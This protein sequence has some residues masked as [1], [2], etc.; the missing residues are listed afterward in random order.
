MI[1]G[2]FRGVFVHRYRDQLSEIRA[3]CIEELGTWIKLDPEHFLNDKCLKYLGWTLH[4]KVSITHAVSYSDIHPR[5]WTR[6]RQSVVFHNEK[7]PVVAHVLCIVIFF[8]S[9]SGVRC[10]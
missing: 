10:V 4:D 5:G 9:F 3:V 6:K 8:L 7:T 2:M 1:S